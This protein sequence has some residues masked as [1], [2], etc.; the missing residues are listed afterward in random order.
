MKWLIIIAFVSINTYANEKELSE[1]WTLTQS[2][3]ERLKSEE[4]Q[5]ELMSL[6]KDRAGRHWIPRVMLGARS[7][8]TNDPGSVLFNNLGQGAVEQEDFA[9]ANINN[10]DDETYTNTSLMIDLPL[11]EGGLKDNQNK[12][13]KKLLESQQLNKEAT[14]TQS[15]SELFVDYGM[16]S[17]N[18]LNSNLL[19]KI[20]RA[21]KNILAKYKVGTKQNPVGYSGLL[22]LKSVINRVDAF[23]VQLAA[24]SDFRLNLI[25]FKTAQENLS[26]KKEKSISQFVAK[27]KE[28]HSKRLSSTKLENFKLKIDAIGYTSDMEQ[29]RYL[30]QVGLF[31][32]SN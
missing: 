19:N 29:A 22:G 10:P 16:I 28:S 14:Y 32:S 31:A 23:L 24:D 17:R 21:T 4:A 3:S 2:N 8:K 27:F 25:R 12:M 26:V 5:L 7:Y 20:N 6:K 1:L 9:E 30:P 13:Y 18:H 15:F 11:Y